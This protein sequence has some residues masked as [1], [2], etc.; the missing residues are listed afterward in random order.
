MTASYRIIIENC[1]EI[2]M[3]NHDKLVD[4]RDRINDIM[5]AYGSNVTVHRE[6]SCELDQDEWVVYRDRVENDQE[7]AA[8]L[9]TEQR[10][11]EHANRKEYE[12]FLRLNAKYGG[13]TPS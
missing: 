4:I 13:F 5:F 12:S 7:L 1:G 10:E 3:N 2:Q 11:L 6:Y 8:R 9:I